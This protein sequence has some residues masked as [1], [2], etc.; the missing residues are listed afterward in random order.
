MNGYYGHAFLWQVD[1]MTDLGTLGGG[2]SCAYGINV[3]NEV[4]GYS[5]VAEFGTDVAYKAFLWRSGKMTDLNIYGVAYSVNNRSQV[6]GVQET[7]SG[8]AR[9]FVWQSGKANLLDTL[10][11]NNSFAYCIADDGEVVGAFRKRSKTNL[12]ACVWRDSHCG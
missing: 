11:G 5:L 10:G 6:V 4:V 12:H 8:D 2:N 1:R 3:L 9:A 7:K